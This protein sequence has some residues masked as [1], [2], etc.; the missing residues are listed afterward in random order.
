MR[1]QSKDFREVIHLRDEADIRYWTE[2]FGVGKTTL[3]AAMRNVGNSVKAL[4]SIF[5]KRAASR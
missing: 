1:T 5:V 2:R 4:D 3:E